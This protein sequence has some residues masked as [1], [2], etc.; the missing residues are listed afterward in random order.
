MRNVFNQYPS[1]STLCKTYLHMCSS[2]EQPRCKQSNLARAANH[3]RGARAHAMASR[4]RASSGSI[5]FLRRG[6][7]SGKM[8]TRSSDARIIELTALTR[9]TCSDTRNR[10]LAPSM[11]PFPN[12]ATDGNT[13]RSMEALSGHS[14]SKP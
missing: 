12:A 5:H 14:T 4:T 11:S 7:S 6:S 13:V 3:G 1:F 10:F 8:P 9:R 2:A